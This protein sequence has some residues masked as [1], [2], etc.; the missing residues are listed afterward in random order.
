MA[1]CTTHQGARPRRA[2]PPG[3]FYGSPFPRK[4]KGRLWRPGERRT[5]N[6]ACRREAPNL[7]R[8]QSARQARD[9]RSR[10]A[11]FQ[12]SKLPNFPQR[13]TRPRSGD[14]GDSGDTGAPLRGVK[15][16]VLQSGGSRRPRGPMRPIGPTASPLGTS[17]TCRGCRENFS[18]P[19]CG[20]APHTFQSANQPIPLWVFVLFVTKNRQS[21]CASTPLI[22]NK[23]AESA[24][25]PHWQS[26]RRQPAPNRL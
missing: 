6:R 9:R 11:N 22:C 21:A 5:E 18:L 14:T 8:P 15:Q 26:C 25:P 23:S 12:A 19:G 16:T 20:V 7:P 10:C 13:R 4:H 2:S 17:Q 1:P 24:V 3:S